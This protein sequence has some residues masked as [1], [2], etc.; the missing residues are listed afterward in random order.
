MY[1][2]RMTTLKLQRNAQRNRSLHESS[3]HL[4]TKFS[5]LWALVKIWIHSYNQ[6]GFC[7]L[8][9]AFGEFQSIYT[10]YIRL[11]KYIVH[12]QNLLHKL[13]TIFWSRKLSWK[14]HYVISLFL[15]FLTQLVTSQTKLQS[16]CYAKNEY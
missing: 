4:V 1:I 2:R 10:K 16:S 13:T 6:L 9:S 11:H 7:I 8:H 3:C 12:K 15:S 14:F 5:S